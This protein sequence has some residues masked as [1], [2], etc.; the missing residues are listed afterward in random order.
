M[1]TLGLESE[2]EYFAHVTAV[3]QLS[4]LLAWA[5]QAKQPVLVLGGGSNLV[6]G[7][8][9]PGLVLHIAIPGWQV[10][11]EE[12][13]HVWLR[14][15]A[16]ENWHET[17]RRT[18][19]AGLSGLENLALIPGTVG[20][21]PVQNIGAYGVEV[22]E[23]LH[24]V[25][26]FDTVEGAV[27][28]LARDECRFG[29]RDSLFKQEPAGRYIITAVEFLLSRTPELRLDYGGVREALGT[30]EAP[31]PMGVFD[32][33]CRIRRSKLPDP[34]EIGNAGSFFQNP[35]VSQAHYEQLKSSYPE[36]VA[37]P[38]GRQWKLAAGW[39]IDRCGLKG[40]RVGDVGTYPRQALVLV[41][42][43]HACRDDILAYAGKIQACVKEKFQVE[44]EPEP[45]F[46]P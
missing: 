30:N 7:R 13:G 4:P 16:G 8:Q 34:S 37:F 9:V 23:R 46:Y 42:W 40:D 10:I 35:I 38:A 11:R 14:V 5:E 21:A 24:Q 17:V 41:N 12:G 25:E 6:L 26:V 44:L 22:G 28:W 18:L 43:G 3:D 19:E 1:N 20:A 27:R 45:R 39:L 29:Y 31:T 15:G 36:L 33:I 32:A 2:A